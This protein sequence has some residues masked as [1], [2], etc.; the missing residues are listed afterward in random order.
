MPRVVSPTVN[1]TSRSQQATGNTL[2]Y[3]TRSARRAHL[4]ESEKSHRGVGRQSE[5]TR[6]ETAVYS[7][8]DKK[9]QPIDAENEY[10]WRRDR[11]SRA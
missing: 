5:F 7:D 9:I 4:S 1:G 6:R 11:L 10:C 3:R 2:G 8:Q